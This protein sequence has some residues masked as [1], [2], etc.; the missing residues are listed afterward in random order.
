MEKRVLKLDFLK[1]S[2]SQAAKDAGAEEVAP[3]AP[4]GAG[5][6]SGTRYEL[7][8]LLFTMGLL[9]YASSRIS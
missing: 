5:G 3:G 8:T 7:E 9:I 4:G 6:S 2:K 1:I